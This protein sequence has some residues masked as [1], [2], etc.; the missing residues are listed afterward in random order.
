M[1]Q[2]TVAHAS[3]VIERAYDAAPARVFAAFTRPDV[4]DQWSAC[5]GDWKR[6]EADIR[7]GGH[8]RGS[9]GAASGGPVWSN[10]TIYLE[11][12]Q[13]RRLVFAYTMDR[14][15]VRVSASLTTVEIHPAAKG[16][17]LVLTEQGAFFDG[18]EDPAGREEGTRLGLDELDRLLNRQAAAA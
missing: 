3:F 9:G 1:T 10:D 4:K 15:G 14:D 7:V 11:I 6:H 18:L 2:H 12:V 16:S 17:R 13:N 5:H 8:E